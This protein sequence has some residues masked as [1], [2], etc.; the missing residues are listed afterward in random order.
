MV[1]PVVMYRCE[2]W[3]IRKAECQ[4]IDALEMWCWR[5]LLRVPWTARRSN[6]S[7]LKEISPEYSLEGLMLKLK[8]QYFGHLI[9]R[10]DS[11]EKTL[12]LGKIEGRRRRGWQRMRWLDGITLGHEFE[13]TPR[14]TEG[15]GS[16]ECC[17]PWGC[18]ESDTTE[19]LNNNNVFTL[20]CLK[21]KVLQ[22]LLEYGTDKHRPLAS[23]KAFK[24]LTVNIWMII[25]MWIFEQ[26]PQD[27]TVCF[28]LIHG[29]GE[30]P[31][32][33]SGNE[34]SGAW[35]C[36]EDPCLPLPPHSR[37]IITMEERK[38][39]R[40]IWPFHSLYWLFQKQTSPRTEVYSYQMDP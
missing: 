16:L 19:Q 1:F 26:L 40:A 29:A 2:N 20:F 5:R 38:A 27:S 14:D 13:Q 31:L 28:C 9:R 33:S 34:T 3:A 35:R 36:G 6:Q 22:N 7:V 18:K 21:N 24:F 11:L 8:L 32:V 17:G 15:Q 12:M 23:M 37:H 4:K 25:L 30:L 10:A 39:I